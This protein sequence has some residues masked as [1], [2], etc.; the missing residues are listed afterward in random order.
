MDEE[1]IELRQQLD[2]VKYSNAAVEAFVDSVEKEHEN[3]LVNMKN[4]KLQ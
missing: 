3:V 1:K 2:R 4:Q